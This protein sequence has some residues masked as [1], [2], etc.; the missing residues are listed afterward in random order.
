MGTYLGIPTVNNLRYLKETL[1]SIK[2]IDNNNILILDNG[3]TDETIYWVA[4]CQ[5]ERILN[6]TNLGVAKAWNQI[7][8]WGLSYDDCEIIYIL[9][10]DIVLH[11]ECITSMTESILANGKE[12]IS[13][14]NIG[15]LPVMLSSFTKSAPERRYTTAVNFSCFGLTPKTIKRVGLFDE[16]FKLAYY[17]DNDYHHRM[18]LE[19]V[20]S[21]CDTW[22]AFTHYGS[23]TIREGGVKHEPYFAQNRAY[24][25]QKWGVDPP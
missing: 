22:A 7:I 10:N 13:G 8:N 23:R 2:G 11:P 5:Y 12:C 3:S 18:N 17:E 16:G 24:F 9:N 1:A 6:G 4:S 25:K 14:L 20:A 19:G 21:S 15:N